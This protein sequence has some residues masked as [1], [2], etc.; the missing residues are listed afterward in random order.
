VKATR[1]HRLLVIIAALG[2]TVWSGSC[3]GEERCS[4]AN[5]PRCGLLKNQVVVTFQTGT[6]RAQVDAINAEIGATVLYA[7]TLTTTYGIRLPEGWCY[8]K[9]IDFYERQ[10]EVVAALFAI[11]LCPDDQDGG[12]DGT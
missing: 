10:P 1:A 3:D 12:S 5:E 2:F 4:A 8:Q 11:S 9:G 6:T 7:P